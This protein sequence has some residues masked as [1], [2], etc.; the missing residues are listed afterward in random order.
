M[1]DLFIGANLTPKL[2]RATPWCA[3]VPYIH[4]VFFVDGGLRV[5]NVLPVD[6]SKRGYYFGD[7]DS[8]PAGAKKYLGQLSQKRVHIFSRRKNF[9]DSEAAIN[10]AKKNIPLRG[11]AVFVGMSG[12]RQDHDLANMLCWFKLHHEGFWEKMCVFTASSQW[13]F[14]RR[15]L[16]CQLPLR[17]PCALFSMSALIQTMGLAYNLDNERLTSFS[18][19]ISNYTV[20]KKISIH[21]RGRQSCLFLIRRPDLRPDVLEQVLATTDKKSI[22]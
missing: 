8:Q 7:R 9:S 19:G 12:G 5:F 13:I 4:R 16:H 11:S 15:Q 17:T 3:L 6:I 18:H 1:L 20:K 21:V 10:F 2:I 14:F 22:D